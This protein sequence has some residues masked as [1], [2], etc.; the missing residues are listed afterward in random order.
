VVVLVVEDA[1]FDAF[2]HVDRQLHAVVA[3]ELDPAELRRVVRGRDEDTGNAGRLAVVA[4]RWRR[5]DAEPVDVAADDRGQPARSG[6]GEQLAGGTGVAGDGDPVGVPGRAG[7]L[8]DS[9]DEFRREIPERDPRMPL[10]PN[11]SM[12]DHAPA[13]GKAV[14]NRGGRDAC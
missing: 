14:P 1:T 11:S 7:G 13:D 5:D 4:D 3:D 8:R 12:S 10:D 9:E 2:E 6:V